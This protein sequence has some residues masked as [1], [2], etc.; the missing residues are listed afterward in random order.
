MYSTMPMTMPSYHDWD[1]PAKVPAYE[2]NESF[3][4]ARDVL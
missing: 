2:V 1:Y 3:R 4:M